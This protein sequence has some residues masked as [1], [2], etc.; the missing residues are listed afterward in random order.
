MHSFGPTSR[1]QLTAAEAAGIVRSNG[2]QFGQ[3]E[4]ERPKFRGSFLGIVLAFTNHGEP[5]SGDDP[6]P[7]P[8]PP[9]PRRQIGDVD[10]SSHPQRRHCTMAMHSLPCTCT[11]AGAA[12]PPARIPTLSQPPQPG[13][14]VTWLPPK[15]IFCPL[16]D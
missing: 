10:P 9:P 13:C 6:P 5:G 8:P 7:P 11:P 4:D 12:F 14:L 15:R 16:P 3:S 2:F 1:V